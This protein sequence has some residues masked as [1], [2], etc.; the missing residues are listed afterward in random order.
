M[1]TRDGKRL[2]F[3]SAREVANRA[4]LYRQ[5]VDGSAAVERLTTS[6]R[7]QRVN[8]LSPDGTRLVFEELS[9]N[10]SFDFKLLRLD[11]KPHVQPLLET[12]FDERNAT[13][14]PDGRWMAYD[15]NE[16]GQNQIYVRPFP[17]VNDAQQQ[18]STEGGRTPAWSPDGRELFFVNRPSMMSVPVKLTPAFVRGQSSQAVRRPRDRDRRPVWRAGGGSTLRTYDV[19]PDGRF[20]M[21]REDARAE[22]DAPGAAMIVVQHW[23]QELKARMAEAAR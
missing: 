18:V 3:G 9:A 22:G 17:N 5:A 6:E 7:Q 21:I 10:G 4:N 11:G 23:F 12:Q 13:I 15:S 8:S 14:S 20:L 16:S 2:I 19:A 1:W